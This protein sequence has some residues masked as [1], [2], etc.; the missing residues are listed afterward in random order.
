MIDV[1]THQHFEQIAYGLRKLSGFNPEALGWSNFRNIIKHRMQVCLIDDLAN[2]SYLLEHSNAER[3][4]LIEATVIPESWFFRDVISFQALKQ[5]AINWQHYT[6]L[7]LRVLSI[8]CA[9]GEEPY[10]IAITLHEAG[11]MP[12][13]FHI[14][15][16]DISTAAITKAMQGVY[17]DNAFRNKA[18]DFRDQYFNKTSQGYKLTDT[19]RNSVSFN[20]NNFFIYSVLWQ[21]DVVFC[22]NLLIYFDKE[23]RSQAFSHLHS[24]LTYDGWLFLG[25][26][27]AIQ[28]IHYGWKTT[29]YPNVFRK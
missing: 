17:T 13:Q 7:P 4:A 19:I 12:N 18:V 26:S 14:D 8:P 28:A 11:L 6:N 9:S 24:L 21:Y 5:V 29:I 25:H 3:G 15:A 23:M 22:R 20:V 1:I 16:V 27:E 2:Y 10:S